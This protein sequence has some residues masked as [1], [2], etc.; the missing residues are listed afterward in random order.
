MPNFEWADMFTFW[1]IIYSVVTC[2][3]YFVEQKGQTT[4]C[5][6]VAFCLWKMKWGVLL[7]VHKIMYK[8]GPTWVCFR[9]GFIM[10][11]VNAISST[12][13]GWFLPVWKQHFLSMLSSGECESL[14]TL[15]AHTQHVYRHLVTLFL[16]FFSHAECLCHEVAS[17][18]W[19]TSCL[20]S[21]SSSGLVL[22][23]SS[24]KY[25]FGRLWNHI[26]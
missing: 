20:S 17:A 10:A 7:K 21:T 8:R 25:Q 24:V 1:P 23:Y 12:T 14:L 5:D 19:S 2:G 4:K 9:R 18:V 3:L 26:Q 13:Q 6:C 11:L 15:K 16:S 22:L